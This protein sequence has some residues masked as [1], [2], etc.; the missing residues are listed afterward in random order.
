MIND[1]N[2]F[3]YGQVVIYDSI[4]GSLTFEPTNFVGSGTYNTWTVIGSGQ[5]RQMFAK[6]RLEH[7]YVVLGK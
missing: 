1:E 7:N 6:F 2:N 4:T 3:L 5:G